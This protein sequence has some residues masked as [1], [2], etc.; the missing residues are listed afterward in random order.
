MKKNNGKKTWKKSKRDRKLVR[1]QGT[2]LLK[3]EIPKNYVAYIR[4]LSRKTNKSIDSI[5]DHILR[6]G[7]NTAKEVIEKDQEK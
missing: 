1:R 4:E 3:I 6:G 2:V 7:M 5:L